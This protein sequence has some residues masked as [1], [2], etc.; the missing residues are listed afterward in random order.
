MTVT[1]QS[2]FSPYQPPNY[3]HNICSECGQ[4]TIVSDPSSGELIC[5]SCGL[6]IK[7]TFLNSEPEWR[8]FTLADQKAQTRVGAPMSMTKF[9]KGLSTTFQPFKD[10]H[11]RYLSST[12]RLK[13][14]RLRRWNYRAQQYTSIHR[15]LNQAMNAVTRLA[16]A[17]H[18]PRAVK[19]TA[20]FLYRKAL[21]LDLV[22]GRSIKGVAAASLYLACR[23]SQTPRSLKQVA[24]VSSRNR[25]EIA[26]CYRLLLHELNIKIPVDRPIKYVPEIASKVG[27]DQ[28]T[29]NQ[30]IKLLT[31]AKKQLVTTG[32]APKGIAAAALYIASIMK[33]KNITQRE[34]AEASGVTEVTVRNRYKQLKQ[35]LQITLRPH[36]WRKIR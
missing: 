5:S 34:I 14:M 4:K 7:D 17:L 27:L 8:A 29:Q 9:D 33:N 35:D 10:A 18:I 16:E 36:S 31:H 6:V 30:A 26:R 20:A 24:D 3:H 22:K 12:K 23:T 1:S 2:V 13:M 28:H 19:N 11:G 32:K 25:K 15:N 21:N